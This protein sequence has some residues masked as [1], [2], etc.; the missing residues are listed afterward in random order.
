MSEKYKIHDNGG[1]PFE[2][3]IDRDAKT[4]SVSQH[5]DHERHLCDDRCIYDPLIEWTYRQVWI[6][7]GT[8]LPDE[9]QGAWTFGNTILVEPITQDDDEKIT[10]TKLVIITGDILSFELKEIGEIVTRFSSRI[11]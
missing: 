8:D 1:R 9:D 3:S 6:G 11:G 4:V 10:P 7:R 2:V 5:R